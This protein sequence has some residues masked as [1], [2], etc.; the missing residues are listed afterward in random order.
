MPLSNIKY[1]GQDAFST[2][3][4]FDM[5]FNDNDNNILNSDNLNKDDAKYFENNLL[6]H[7]NAEWM[8]DDQLLNIASIVVVDYNIM[9]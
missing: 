8:L 6:E 9:H 3:A 2:N 5:I 4:D 7:I 1:V